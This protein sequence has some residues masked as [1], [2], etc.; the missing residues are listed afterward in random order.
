MGQLLP[1]HG[2]QLLAHEL[3]HPEGLG[4]VGDHV[5]GVVPGPFG[6]AGHDGI[7]QLGHP[8]AGAGRDGEVLGQVELAGPCQLLQDLSR[9]GGVDLVDDHEGAFRDPP[10]DEPVA[11]AERGHAEIEK[12]HV[13]PSAQ[14]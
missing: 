5:V 4:H 6:Q 12:H 3:G 11:L 1:G 10:G 8:L 7:D 2:Q 9:A 14:R 13:S